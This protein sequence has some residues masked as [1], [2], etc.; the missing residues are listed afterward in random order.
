MS[1]NGSLML[2][3]MVPPR[4]DINSLKMLVGEEDMRLVLLISTGERSF[5]RHQAA[6]EVYLRLPP[7]ALIIPML[8]RAF[9]LR[10]TT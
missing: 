3:T 5:T 6:G 7:T 9:L 4:R 2:E 8:L 10:Y 1:G